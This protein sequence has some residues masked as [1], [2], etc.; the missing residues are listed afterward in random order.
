MSDTIN[1]LFIDTVS[2]RENNDGGGEIRIKTESGNRVTV[3]VDR[4]DWWEVEDQLEDLD[5][6]TLKSG[7]EIQMIAKRDI[8]DDI[9]DV[10]EIWAEK[11]ELWQEAKK[12]IRDG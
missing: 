11:R 8:P 5:D 9:D 2:F 6:E 12:E 10:Q 3:F 1:G 7:E 4:T